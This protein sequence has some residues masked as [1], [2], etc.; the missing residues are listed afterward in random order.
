ML[1]KAAIFLL[2]LPGLCSR[3]QPFPQLRWAQLT[4]RD[5]LTC[6]NASSVTQDDDGLIWIATSNGLNRFDG[7]GCT[8][9]F[10]SP[11]DTAALP[12]NEIIRVDAGR[13][14]DLWL[15][16]V[17]GLCRYDL[18]TRKFNRFQKGPSTPSIFRIYNGAEIWFDHKGDAYITSPTGL[19]HFTDPAHYTRMDEGFTPFTSRERIQNAY[20]GIV[21]DRTGR[22]WAFQAN[23]IYQLDSATKKVIRSWNLKPSIAIYGLIFDHLN[24]GWVSTWHSGIFRFEPASGAYAAIPRQDPPAGLPASPGS[25]I[26]G[27]GTE[28]TL[29]GRSYLVY[30]SNDPGL[31]LVDEETGR[32]RLYLHL[33]GLNNFGPPFVDRQNILWVTTN[34]GVYY[35]NSADN[36]WD[37]LPLTMS[38]TEVPD[39]SDRSTPYVMRE[40]PSG[41]WIGRRYS[42]GMLWYDRN[43]RLIRGWKT[44]VNPSGR[45]G[46]KGGPTT[47]EA[48]DFHQVGDEMYITTEWGMVILNLRTFRRTLIPCPGPTAVSRLRT[49]VPVDDRHWWIRS[50]DQGIFVFDPESRRFTRHYSL[51]S[52]CADCG[53]PQCTYLL[54]DHHGRL[55]AA[56]NGGLFRYDP[57]SDSFVDLR[58]GGIPGL[59]NA[60][61]GMAEDRAGLIWIG[62]D[63]GICAYDPESG[64]VVRTLSENNTIGG[65]N[66]VTV[67][68]AQN[69]WFTSPAG[70]WCWLRRQQKTIQFPLGKGLPDNTESLFYTASNGNVYAG[71]TGALVWFHT[72]MLRDYNVAETVRIVDVLAGDSV[73]IPKTDGMGVKRLVLG[74]DRNNLQVSFDVINYDVPANNLFFYRLQPGPGIWV[75][76]DNG[77][78]SFNNLPAGEYELTVRGGNKLTGAFT[79]TDK[80]IF[81]IKPWWWLSTWFKVLVVLALAALAAALAVVLV[82][83]RIRNIR[84]EWAFRQKIAETEMQALRAQMNP[85]FLFNSLNSIENFILKNEKWLASDYLNKFARLFRMILQSSRNELVPFSKDLEALQLYVDLE[86][87]RYNNKFVYETEIDPLLTDSEFRVPSLLIQPYVENAIV[88]GL[89]LSTREDGY[90]RVAATLDGEYICYRITDNGV[91]RPQAR[92]V[93]RIN[94]PNH[95]SVGLTIT[96]NR[97]NIF[98]HQQ[99]SA[100]RVTITDLSNE[101]GTAAG[102]RVE[103]MIKAV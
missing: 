76:V 39:G 35:L 93:R 32:S 63:H 14:H 30:P 72:D 85:H 64:S 96:E 12:A 95:H 24:H 4:E 31:L 18:A 8:R 53:A 67:D 21:A 25:D 47:H 60:T 33:P 92:E 6:D 77:K 65:V 28:W 54:R 16:T 2:L 100:G 75:Q 61:F 13:H 50:F 98:S 46:P 83:R 62:L 45:P 74:P 1:R 3:S 17:S 42:G 69:I 80:M 97:I 90:V 49:I 9:F 48:Y 34:N 70:Y 10:A 43:W 88:H 37:L 7:F 102:T 81:V 99:N 52:S 78:L 101:D 87:L 11:D 82:R 103:V 56:T 27:V 59:G 26:V 40:E 15:Q 89:G 20:R 23:V 84:R 57:A 58:P 73:L 71:C 94:N 86:R 44:V 51:Q 22:L 38:G 41:Y 91:G 79:G 19:W 55:F 66:R 68:S 36:L 5:G 29:N